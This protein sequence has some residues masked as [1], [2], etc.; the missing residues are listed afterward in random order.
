MHLSRHARLLTPALLCALVLAGCDSDSTP[1]TAEPATTLSG[2]AATGAPLAGAGLVIRCGSG[3]SR[4]TTT[5]GTGSFSVSVPTSSLPCA[6]RATPAGGGTALHAVTTGSG[7][8]LTVNVTP[9]T[10]LIAALSVNTVASQA[11]ATW[12]DNPTNLAGISAGLATAQTT[13]QSALTT[14]GYALPSPFAPIDT[15][16]SADFTVDEYDRLLEAIAAGMS[17]AA[18]DYDALLADLIDGTPALPAAPGA[19][20]I[21]SLSATSGAV[22]DEITLTGSGF[23]DDPFH[24]E[25]RFADN[26]A[27]I[28]VSVTDTDLVV[29]VPDGAVDG[30]ISVRNIITD[31]SDTSASFTIGD[32]GGTPAT[33]TGRAAPSGFMQNGVAY[34]S[35]KFVSVGYNRT[36]LT[37]TDGISWTARTAPD[38]NFYQGNSVTWD[39]NQFVLVGDS[40]NLAT[41]VPVIAT[42]PDGVTWTRRSWTNGG[43]E[44]QLVDVAGTASRLTAVGMNGAIITSTDAGA[45]WSSEAAPGGTITSLAG[46]ADNGSL[47]IAVGRN[48]S[49][50]GVLIANSGSGWA[51]TGTPA[52]NW[53]PRDVIWT[54]SLWV[55]VGADS[56]IGGANAVVMYSS[57]GSAWTRVDLPTDATPAGYALRDITWT[58]SQFVAVGDN[59]MSSRVVVTSPDAATWT[60]AFLGSV[61]GNGAL[62][63]VASGGGIVVAI[64]G[65]GTVTSP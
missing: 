59:G 18:V 19:V 44:T 37:S 9:L 58:G 32:G 48:S 45:S 40:S 49:S 26:V 10:D 12:F 5:S 4:T 38:S 11:L 29:K 51:Q 6:L 8:S 13:L 20:D 35:S 1:T 16:F 15:P 2:T 53:V 52:S 43:G 64:G 28:I 42:S 30:T 63:S 33:W 21:S 50:Q 41:Y 47:R 7:G 22:D 14:A 34:G 17:G 25:V 62:E 60:Q 55:V 57:D 3:V 61:M 27:A 39:G 54:G 24:L 46:I 56:V 31:T 65:N 23:G 36:I